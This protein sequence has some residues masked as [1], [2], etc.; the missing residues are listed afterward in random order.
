V[1]LVRFGVNGSF[2]LNAKKSAYVDWYRTL[3]VCVQAPCKLRARSVQVCARATEKRFMK[4]CNA[5]ALHVP[6]EEFVSFI[7]SA[8]KL[9]ENMQRKSVARFHATWMQEFASFT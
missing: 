7:P 6:T 3:Q 8:S 5:F 1:C 2:Y 4:S 9:H